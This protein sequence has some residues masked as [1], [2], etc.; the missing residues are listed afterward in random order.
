MLTLTVHTLLGES[1]VNVSL[2]C[3]P[4]LVRYCSNP[5]RLVIHEDGSLTEPSRDALR[6][7]LP[8]VEFINREKAD[9]EIEARLNGYPRCIASRNRNIMFLKLFDVSLLEPEELLYCDS[10]I[11]FLRPFSG[12]FGPAK[13]RFPALFM[14]D[15][16]EAYSVR[17]WHLRPL[18]Q[19]RL[20]SRVNAGLMRINPGVLD[21]DFVEWLLKKMDGHS[22]WT[23]R[24]YWNEQ[25]CW[26][27]LAGRSGCGL[28]DRQKVLMA[29][30]DMALYTSD[31]V[32]IHFVSTYRN[33]LEYYATKCLQ[34]I[35]SSIF[36]NSFE[37]KYVNS[38][39][40]FVSDVR[41]RRGVTGE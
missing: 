38:I 7:A 32:A 5:I 40:Q 23:R 22:V 16:K 24:S 25:T 3:L 15:T 21:L 8:G 2:V 19:I 17:P 27:A 36:I 1:T 12:L 13:S 34:E 37:S 11:L 26:A 14:T 6:V 28:W 10:D 33:H 9:E 39:D 4:T 31:A 41:A 30:P 29:S 20:A 35:S 18:G